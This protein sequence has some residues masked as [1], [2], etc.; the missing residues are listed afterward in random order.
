MSSVDYLKRLTAFAKNQHLEKAWQNAIS[1]CDTDMKQAAS[2]GLD[3]AV[4]CLPSHLL[5][6]VARH[7]KSTGFTVEWILENGSAR[8]LKIS[9]DK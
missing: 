5:D 1:T 3:S 2:I 8:A 4:C 9:W 6:P 7:Y